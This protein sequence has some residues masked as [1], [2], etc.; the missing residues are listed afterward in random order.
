[1]LLADLTPRRRLLLDAGLRVVVAQGL[2]GLTHRAVDREA[3]LPEGSTSAYLRTRRALQ[4]ALAEY[5]AARLAADVDEVAERLI[6]CAPGSDAAVGHV[7]GLFGRWVEEG[8]LVQAKVELTL[9]AARDPELAEIIATGRRQ[10][11]EVVVGILD[12]E[13]VEAPLDRAEALVSAFDGILLAALLKPARERTA[14]L[15]SALAVT[16]HPLVAE[17]EAG[18]A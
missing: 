14:F 5:V 16:M 3:G 4:T 6:D 17:Q 15:A 18:Q 7:L 12:H 13:H 10:V 11:V 1:M 9:E 2:R 8:A